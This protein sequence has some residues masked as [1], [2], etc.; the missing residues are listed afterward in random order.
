MLPCAHVGGSSASLLLHFYAQCV[1]YIDK[2]RIF[3]G[4]LVHSLIFTSLLFAS[5]PGGEVM[6]MKVRWQ[7]TLSHYD[8]IIKTNPLFR[9]VQIHRNR[10]LRRDWYY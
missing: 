6:S 1:R 8:I 7:R 5:I 2:S 3:R 10:Y 9:L 4:I